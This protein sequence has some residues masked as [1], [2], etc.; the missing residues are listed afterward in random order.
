[1]IILDGEIAVIVDSQAQTVSGAKI[2]IIP[3]NTWH[4]FKIRKAG[5]CGKHT[6]G[7]ENDH[8]VDLA[9]D[10]DHWQANHG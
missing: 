10:P 1:V 4:E 2:V 9:Q 5:T 6:P 7:A 3:A 8:G